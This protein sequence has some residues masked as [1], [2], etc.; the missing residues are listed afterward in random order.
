MCV[1][2][3]SYLDLYLHLSWWGW[4]ARSTQI[5]SF[6]SFLF[7]HP[8]DSRGYFLGCLPTSQTSPTAATLA[9]WSPQAW[10][11]SSAFPSAG[12]SS[13]S[14][15]FTTIFCKSVSPGTLTAGKAPFEKRPTPRL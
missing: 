3:K 11:T 1:G 5:T 15:K 7:L 2:G 9:G 10:V 14:D 12:S 13:R 4:R 8:P 6:S